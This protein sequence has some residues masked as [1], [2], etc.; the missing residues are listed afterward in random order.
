M[1]C[2]DE[3]F[4]LI[5][6][7]SSSY[8]LVLI[9]Y[10]S[11]DRRRMHQVLDNKLPCHKISFR[12]HDHVAET[13]ALVA[14]CNEC[15]HKNLLKDY[16]YGEDCCDSGYSGFCNKCG[17]YYCISSCCEDS[18]KRIKKNN[19]IIIGRC[20]KG[21]RSSKPTYDKT[22]D[23]GYCDTYYI[24]KIPEHIDYKRVKKE[25]VLNYIDRHVCVQNFY[26]TNKIKFNWSE[27]HYKL[28]S[29]YYWPTNSKYEIITLLCCANF[30]DNMTS[31]LCPDTL[32]IIFSHVTLQHIANM[33][34][35]SY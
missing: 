34:H 19:S 6:N 29:R 27:S 28:Y 20:V 21:Y 9:I 17:H 10:D 18:F 26:R 32:E 30:S 2:H 11:D 5:H 3:I 35:N 24:V 25:V 15:F 31:L 13:R 4:E 16:K 7:L 33:R 23:A 14:E 12:V 8:A 1:I 22:T